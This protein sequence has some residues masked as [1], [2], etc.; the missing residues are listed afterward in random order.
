SALCSSAT[1]VA[2]SP[3]LGRRGAEGG[4]SP[5]PR[6][7][8]SCATNA[9]ARTRGPSSKGGIPM[10]RAL[11]IAAVLTALARLV[12]GSTAADLCP[13]A[14]NPCTVSPDK[15]VDPASMLDLGTRQLDITP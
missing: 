11:L 7:F 3:R 9:C 6:F 10:S 1:R 2:T 15:I 4:A 14:A 8:G 13:A 12:H 5:H